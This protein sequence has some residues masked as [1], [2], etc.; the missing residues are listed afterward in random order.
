[1]RAFLVCVH[2]ATPAYTRE[3]MA[4]VRDLAPLTGRRLSFGVVPNWHGEWPLAAHPDYCRLVQRT[5]EELLLHGYFHRRERGYG[6]VTWLAERADEMN[7]LNVEETRLILERGQRDFMDVFGETPKG[8]LAPGWQ[9]G[10]LRR[11]NQDAFGLQ[12]RLGY[13]S[14]ESH[15]GRSI[16]LATWTWDC[17]RWGILGHAGHAI[18]AIRRSGRRV[19]VLAIHPRDLARG[20]WPKILRVIER[21]LDA[22]YEPVTATRLLESEC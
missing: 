15:S 10:R 8:F 3:T 18:G 17:G 19:P 1:M 20:F 13:F 9:P 16:P 12:H 21:L 6:P 5:S 14:L 4:I 7:G 22:G 2:D 11:L